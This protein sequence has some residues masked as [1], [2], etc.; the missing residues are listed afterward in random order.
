MNILYYIY[1]IY[2]STAYEFA[3]ASHFP[4][5]ILRHFPPSPNAA[6]PTVSTASALEGWSGAVVPDR[7]APPP[8]PL[9]D[10]GGRYEAEVYPLLGDAPRSGGVVGRGNVLGSPISHEPLETC[11]E[12]IIGKAGDDG[13]TKAEVT[14]RTQFVDHRRRNTALAEL[15]K[16]GK[17]VAVRQPTATKPTIVLRLAGTCEGAPAPETEVPLAIAAPPP[18]APVI[19]ALDLGQRT[20][21]AVATAMAPSPAAS[22][23]SGPAGSR[24]AA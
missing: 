20:G 18:Q 13:L 11:I 2:I 9:H 8:P 22:R 14:R 1:I 6:H 21:W 10:P 17:I 16:A 3:A 15:I 12:T 5:R 19:L 24:A 23:S 7:T 4:L